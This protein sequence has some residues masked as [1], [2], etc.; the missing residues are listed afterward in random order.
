MG[1][2]MTQDQHW[3]A[4]NLINITTQAQMELILPLGTVTWETLRSCQTLD[5]VFAT[6][7]IQDSLQSC[8]VCQE[9][10]TGSDHLPIQTKIQGRAPIQ[11]LQT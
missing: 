9:L 7:G 1:G 2:N 11:R 8:T 5:L 10:E 6:Q 3:A 4:N